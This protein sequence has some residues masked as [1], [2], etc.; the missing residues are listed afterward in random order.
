VEEQFNAFITGF[1]ELIPADLVNVFDEREL[2]LLIGGIADI[3]VDD[4]KKHTDYRGYQEQ[5]ETIQNFWK[6]SYSI[7]TLCY[8]LALTA[9]IGHSFLGCRAEVSSPAVR[10][11]YFAYSCQRLQ[12]SARK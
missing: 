6:V 1:N 7:Y 2:E 10:N 11:R 5:D 4:W 9:T 12:G 3:D 8:K